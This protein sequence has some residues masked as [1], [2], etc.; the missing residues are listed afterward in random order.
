MITING[1]IQKEYTILE[2]N[3]V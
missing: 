3:I 1:Q 2:H